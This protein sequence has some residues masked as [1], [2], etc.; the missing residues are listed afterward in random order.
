MGEEWRTLGRNRERLIV[1]GRVLEVR[2]LEDRFHYKLEVVGEQDDNSDD[3]KRH[4]NK[5]ESKNYKSHTA[6]GLTSEVETNGDVE[7]HIDVGYQSEKPAVEP[8][9]TKPG[10]RMPKKRK[11][12]NWLV[13]ITSGEQIQGK[14]RTAKSKTQKKDGEESNIGVMKSEENVEAIKINEKAEMKKKEN[15]RS[16]ESNDIEESEN[17]LCEESHDIEESDQVVDDDE[18]ETKLDNGPSTTKF[19]VLITED[20]LRDSDEEKY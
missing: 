1:E 11:L 4:N 9:P 20:D 12:P 7:K 16:E 14:A 17:R 15:R 3:T 5:I 19:P 2:M 18:T 6:G 8:E 10:F 13:E